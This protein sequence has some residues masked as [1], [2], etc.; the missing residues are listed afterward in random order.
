LQLNV[1]DI[2]LIKY[3]LCIA[4]TPQ[5]SGNKVNLE[6]INLLQLTFQIIFQI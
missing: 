4:T 3:P 2:A 5:L 6:F 1:A